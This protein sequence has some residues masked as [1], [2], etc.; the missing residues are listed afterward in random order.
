MNATMHNEQKIV[1]RRDNDA[2]VSTYFVY[3]A[4]ATLNCDGPCI[5][6]CETYTDLLLRHGEP[7]G[8]FTNCGGTLAL[9]PS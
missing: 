9:L 4:D 1:L 6:V 8:Y 2:A 5:D 3:L 7:V